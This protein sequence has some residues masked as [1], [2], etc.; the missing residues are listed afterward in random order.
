MTA[1]MFYV[2]AIYC[3]LSCKLNYLKWDNSVEWRIHEVNV[4]WLKI[5]IPHCFPCIMENS[6]WRELWSVWTN[7][8]KC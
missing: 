8:C 7:T 6:I 3:I 4:G 5:V 1:Y 2:C